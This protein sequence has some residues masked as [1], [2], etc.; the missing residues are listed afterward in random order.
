MRYFVAVGGRDSV[1]FKDAE[2]VMKSLE[3]THKDNA[4]EALRFFEA[5]TE[6]QGA[7]LLD[8]RLPVRF[9]AARFLHASLFEHAASFPW[10]ERPNPLGDTD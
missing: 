7:A 5:D 6:L 2:R 8:E 9:E 1:A 4:D 3:R 10:Q